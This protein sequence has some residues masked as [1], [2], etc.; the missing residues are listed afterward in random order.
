[1]SCQLENKFVEDKKRMDV[2]LELCPILCLSL[3]AD[4][5]MMIPHIKMERTFGLHVFYLLSR[6]SGKTL[7]PH[8]QVNIT[9]YKPC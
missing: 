3:I 5:L 7:A 1:M 6:K 9:F 8:H 2:N 4:E